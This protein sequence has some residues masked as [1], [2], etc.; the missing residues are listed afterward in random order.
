MP[1]SIKWP[2][3]II[4]SVILLLVLTT[5]T[6]AFAT[7]PV[8][9]KKYSV[10]R[11]QIE[12]SKDKKVIERGKYLAHTIT[13][14]AHCHGDDLSGK[15]L[16]NDMFVGRIWSGNLTPGEGG[17]G[18]FS[19]EDWVNVIRYGV[20][21]NGRAANFM[22]SETFMNI[23]K[24]DLTAL[25]SYFSTLK[26]IDAVHPKNKIGPVARGLYLAGKLPVM[27]PPETVDFKADYPPM[28]EPAVN[29]RYGKYLVDIGGCRDCHGS[30]LKG[31]PSTVAPPGTPPAP[32]ITA[33][34]TAKEWDKEKFIKVMNTGV[35]T[36][37]EKL[38]TWMPWEYMGKMTDNDLEAIY[39]Y[40]NTQK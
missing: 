23:S 18:D 25:V 31:R 30:D 13:G 19:A 29:A 21:D 24:E 6:L 8:L 20:I 4:A 12:V 33:T 28:A 5:Y 10:S 3:R 7:N 32:D 27:V 34:G 2:L 15:L 40:L 35:V 36:K 22:P 39:I 1:R 26:P 11:S 16:N 38:N 9:K 37:T 17:V 14:C